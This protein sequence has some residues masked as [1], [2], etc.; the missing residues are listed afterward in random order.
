MGYLKDLGI[1]NAGGITKLITKHFNDKGIPVSLD[2]IK[3]PNYVRCYWSVN[4]N[5]YHYDIKD[6]FVIYVI[7]EYSITFLIQEI[8]ASLKQRK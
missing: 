1:K 2:C 8:E 5:L 6:S 7:N 3:T 4:N